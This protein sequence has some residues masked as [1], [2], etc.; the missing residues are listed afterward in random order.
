ML[1]LLIESIFSKH[2]SSP[3]FWMISFRQTY[4][5]IHMKFSTGDDHVR[6][7]N[8][9]TQLNNYFA[10]FRWFRVLILHQLL[11]ENQFLFFNYSSLVLE[12]SVPR[13]RQKDV[14]R[15]ISPP[16]STPGRFPSYLLLTSLLCFFLVL[17]LTGLFFYIFPGFFAI[18][19]LL[20]SKNNNNIY[21]CEE[22]RTKS[23]GIDRHYILLGPHIEDMMGL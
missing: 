21:I 11:T 16:N 5:K 3:D 22:I 4:M 13:S 7:F 19:I 6:F 8:S 2:F 9:L 1:S 20:S 10:Y 17:Y 12:F 14:E 23:D 15:V 18:F